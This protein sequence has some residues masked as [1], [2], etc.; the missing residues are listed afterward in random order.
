LL[1]TGAKRVLASDGSQNHDWTLFLKIFVKFPEAAVHIV[2]VSRIVSAAVSTL[3]LHQ[4]PRYS[5]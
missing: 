4:H 2:V 3:T 5:C 1:A